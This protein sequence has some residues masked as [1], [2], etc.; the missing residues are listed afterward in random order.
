MDLD[1]RPVVVARSFTEVLSSK[2]LPILESSSVFIAGFLPLSQNI[3]PASRFQTGLLVEIMNRN[4]VP[5]CTIMYFIIFSAN[6]TTVMKM[7]EG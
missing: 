4:R 7:F 2:A 5:I 3:Q 1:S 6:L